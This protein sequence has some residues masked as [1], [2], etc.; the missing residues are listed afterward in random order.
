MAQGASIRRASAEEILAG[1]KR[2][3]LVVTHTTPPAVQSAM[4]IVTD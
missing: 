3:K 2:P 4:L 1:D